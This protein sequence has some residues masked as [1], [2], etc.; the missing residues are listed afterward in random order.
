M[1]IDDLTYIYLN[2][3]TWH[4]NKLSQEEA[5]KYHERLLMQ[6]NI[7][8]YVD[9]GKLI[10]YVEAW[11]INYDQLGR[12]LCEVPFYVF[13]EDITNGNIAY[14]HNMWISPEYRG[15][16]VKNKILKEFFTKFS[17]CQYLFLRRVKWNYAFKVYP[18]SNFIRS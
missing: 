5:N 7:L 10:G 17:D 13:D 9:N 3:E 12:I 2:F 15:N 8:T 16:L 11:K 4:K 14:I 18:M 6:G 1:I